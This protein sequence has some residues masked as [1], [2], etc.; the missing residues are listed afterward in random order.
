MDNKTKEQLT[1]DFK[2]KHHLS[3]IDLMH[4][5]KYEEV[6][7][8]GSM[9]M[10]YYLGDMKRRNHNGTSQLADWILGNYGEYLDYLKSISNNVVRCK[11]CDTPVGSDAHGLFCP[12]CKKYCD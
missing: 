6:R 3:D 2:S 9:N 12:E 10:L 4:L 8:A 5:K 11:D 7:L 1:N